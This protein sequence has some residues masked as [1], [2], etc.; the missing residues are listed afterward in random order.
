[1]NNDLKL[2]FILNGLLADWF[3]WRRQY[4]MTR[5]YS[6]RDSTSR[7]YRT[8]GHWDWQ[9][10]AADAKADDLVMRAFDKCV[11]RVPNHPHLWNTAL[12]YEAMNIHAGA[13]VWSSPRLPRDPDERA[14]LVLEARNMLM[15]ELRKAGVMG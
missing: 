9:N 11:E 10:G 13:A 5:G 7:D 12:Q 1:M 3:V 8:P 15:V 6:S 4:K 2:D 14:V